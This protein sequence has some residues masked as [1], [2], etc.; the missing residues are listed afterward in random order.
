MSGLTVH[1][2]I[3][4][5]WDLHDANPGKP[6][7]IGD[8]TEHLKATTDELRPLLRELEEHRILRRRAGGWAPW[9]AK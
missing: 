3:R 6:V 5:F 1:T 7:Y 9:K 8:L 2:V 4:G